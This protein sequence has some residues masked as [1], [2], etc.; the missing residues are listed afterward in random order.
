[1]PSLVPF[2]LSSMRFDRSGSPDCTAWRETLWQDVQKLPRRLGLVV[3]L[4]YLGEHGSPLTFQEIGRKLGISDER[5][6]QLLKTALLRLRF[7]CRELK[8]LDPT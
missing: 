3:E 7:I 1:M 4:R 5:V 2:A 8:E 6:R